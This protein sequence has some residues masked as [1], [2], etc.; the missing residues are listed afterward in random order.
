MEARL[1]IQLFTI[2]TLA[3]LL[4]NCAALAQTQGEKDKDSTA[5]PP[6]G[7]V[8][9]LPEMTVAAPP[10][11]E[12]AYTVPN[13]TTATKTDTPIMETPVSI[14]VIPQQVLKDQQTT[15]LDQAVKNV[16]G[17]YSSSLFQGQSGDEFVIR[18]FRNNNIVYRDGFRLDNTNLGKTDLAN[19]ERIEIL[20]G[21]ASILYGRIEPGGLINY[22][23]KKP[24]STP[25]YSLQQQFG[26][27]NSYRTTFD[28]TGPL[29]ANN[30][31]N[32]RLNFAYENSNSFRQFVGVERYFIAP[33]LEWNIT[34]RTQ[35]RLE[36]DHL[37]ND[38]TPDNIGLIALGNRPAPIPKER[39]LGEPTDFQNAVQDIVG[40]SFSHALHAQW[41]LNGRFNAE[42]TESEDGGAFGDIF[43]D[44]DLIDGHILPR[45]G[46]GLIGLAETSDRFT[47]AL[48]LD[49]TGKFT[50]GPLAHTLLLGGD[51]YHK[52][53]DSVCCNIR[54]F[55]IDN[56][57]IFAP[58]HGV[59]LDP[60]DTS[61][62][63]PSHSLTKWYG[64]YLQDQIELPYHVFLLAGFS[65]DNAD[66]SSDSPFGS[67]NS[68]DDQAS[69]RGGLL[70]R[71]LPW[72]SLYGSYVEN[73]G[74]GNG[75]LFD[76][77]G[78]PLP[79]ETAQQWELGAKT[80]FFDGRLGG[81]FA[82]FDLTKQNIAATDPLDP[83]NP[84]RAIPIGEANSHGVELDVA[85]ELSPGWNFLANY[86]YTEAT[87][88]KDNFFGSEGRRLANVPQN[89]GRLW[90]TYRVQA[91][92]F[93]GLT[94]G[95][96]VTARDQRQGNNTNDFQLPSYAT[97]ELMA[98]YQF[99][100]GV[101]RVTLQLN[102]DNLLD[103]DFF[104]SSADFGR[105]RIRPGAPR[106]FF[107]LMKAEF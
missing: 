58:V 73:F 81:S 82:Y 95:G 3:A 39:N 2:A 41:Q 6:V 90:S 72:L 84:L 86:A 96:G 106:S 38:T 40:L 45:Q 44:D 12:K 42:I 75:S 63:S 50:T 49:L 61:F 18:G 10:V 67:G 93:R 55:N 29:L 66:E 33:V 48:G 27:F 99:T 74:A 107:G 94:L 20:K 37:H 11:D 15:R 51:Y 43:S 13:A 4:L 104:E 52:T 57:D 16:S 14:Q 8:T 7:E 30:T 105:A 54:G 5:Q 26:S 21:P 89:G 70:W 36:L 88:T 64:F 19:V 79:P 76:R 9:A 24:L 23:T 91:G 69:P 97:V 62:A 31:L 59:R 17:V 100:M 102:V 32:Y 85:G 22:V 53:D 35:V 47:Y 68:S 77:N 87:I 1:H 92:A 65:Y 60:V 25:Y 98:G 28:V 71:P 101:S 34:P 103:E 83:E 80:E 78:N 46:Q 56:I